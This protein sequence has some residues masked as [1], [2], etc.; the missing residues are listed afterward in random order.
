MRSRRSHEYENSMLLLFINT[1][2]CKWRKHPTRD[3]IQDLE[4]DFRLLDICPSIYFSHF[5]SS[6]SPSSLEGTMSIVLPVLLF[7]AFN[8]KNR[9]Y[10]LVYYVI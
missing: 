2:Y 1:L 10:N 3:T 9:V 5:G 6:E 4:D 8:F 7:R